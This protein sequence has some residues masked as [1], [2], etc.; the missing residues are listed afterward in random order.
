MQNTRPTKDKLHWLQAVRGIAA[1]AVL[2]FHMTPHWEIVP[3]LSK[4]TG[5][6]RW[7]FSGV[8]VFFILSGFVVYKTA[9]QSMKTLGFWNFLKRRLLRIYF[10]YWPVLILTAFATVFIYKNNLPPIENILFST[11]LLY[12]NIWDNWLPPAWSLT[13]EIYFY[14]WIALIASL[15]QR[16]QIKVIIS[17]ML[18]LACWNIGWLVGDRANVLNGQQ[19]LRYLLT[20][21]GLEFLTGALIAYAYIK[22]HNFLNR[23]FLIIPICIAFASAGIAIG[24]TSPYFDRVEI[25]RAAS[26]GV[27]G[28]AVLI[29]ALTLEGTCLRPPSWLVRIGDASFSLYLLHIFLLDASGK[30]RGFMQINSPSAMFFFMFSLPVVIVLISMYWYHWVEKPIMK[31]ALPAKDKTQVPSSPGGLHT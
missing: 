14:L 20:G 3:A 28:V 19:P 26:F 15:P 27:M 9:K 12:P 7:G 1:L 11:L 21:L 31:M 24:M 30:L 10:G 17:A 2:F 23:P 16:H 5:I 6:M 8:D 29:L 18:L 4:F 22:N 25:M 13:M